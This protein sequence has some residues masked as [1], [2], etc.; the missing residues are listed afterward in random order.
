MYDNLQYASLQHQRFY[1][2]SGY[3]NF[4]YWYPDTDDG[5]EAG[6]NLVDKLMAYIPDRRGTILDVA[7]GQ[8]GTTRRLLEYFDAADIHAINVSARQLEVARRNAPGC[9]FSLMDATDLGF[10]DA[11]FAQVMCVEAAF[12]FDSRERF[13]REAHRVLAPGGRIVLSDMLPR[14]AWLDVLLHRLGVPGTVPEE[15]IESVD[16]YRALL[17]RVG[18][19][20]IAITDALP[21]TYER[22]WRRFL[23]SCTRN[24]CDPSLWPGILVDRI[25]LPGMVPWIAW[26]SLWIG[27][28]VLVGA[29]KPG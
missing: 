2:H 22:F 14:L 11:S 21:E 19:V 24:V 29:R 7:C 12:H 13:L 8:G 10:A 15:N 4:G 5:E 27:S 16:S 20:D 9:A 25:T 28:Y 23:A 17:A 3:C 26:H 1:N 18:F 6:D